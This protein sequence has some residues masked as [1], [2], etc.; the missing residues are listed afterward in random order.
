MKPSRL[1][2]SPKSA[3]MWRCPVSPI[4]HS[5]GTSSR[6]QVMTRQP[7]SLK[8]RAVAWPMPRLA[9]VSMTVLRSS[10]DALLGGGGAA[11]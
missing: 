9:P 5:A 7:A 8:R 11:A 10:M 3:T 4:R 1:L 2:P 6:E